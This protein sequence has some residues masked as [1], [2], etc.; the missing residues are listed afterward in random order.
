[1]NDFRRKINEEIENNP[2]LQEKIYLIFKSLT[3]EEIDN[4]YNIL[5]KVDDDIKTG[6]YVNVK[7]YK[8][9]Y[10]FD[11]IPEYQNNKVYCL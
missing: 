3:P 9:I 11:I 8:Y 4:I 10:R 2:I 1:M 6:N 5:E 7:E